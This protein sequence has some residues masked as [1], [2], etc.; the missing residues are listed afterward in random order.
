MNGRTLSIFSFLV[1]L[2]LLASLLLSTSCDGLL[3][4]I[5]TPLGQQSMLEPGQAVLVTDEQLSIRFKEVLNDSRCPTGVTCIWAG[6]IACL[7]EVTYQDTPNDLVITEMGS[8]PGTAD[9][10]GYTFAFNVQPYP[11]AGKTINSSDYRLML[12]VNRS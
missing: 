8:G 12:T 3:P 7:L 5:N 2:L 6:Q 11:Q 4:D 1:L 10:N 9:F